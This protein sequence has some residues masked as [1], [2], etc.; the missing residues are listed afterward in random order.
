M[1]CVLFFSSAKYM[2]IMKENYVH[3]TLEIFAIVAL[4]VAISYVA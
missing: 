3:L 1:L 2:Q 4:L